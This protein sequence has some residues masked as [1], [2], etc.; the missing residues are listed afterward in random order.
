MTQAK[1]LAALKEA[2]VTAYMVRC[3]YD[4]DAERQYR[5]IAEATGGAYMNFA[6]LGGGEALFD[7]QEFAI[8]DA[9]GEDVR[10]LIEERASSGQLEGGSARALLQVFD[11][12]ARGG[13]G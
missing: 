9:A 1:I 13:S 6:D 8:R 11:K 2:G 3:G 7:V 10:A 12:E 4:A 5:E